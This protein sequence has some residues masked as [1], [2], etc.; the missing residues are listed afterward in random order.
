MAEYNSREGV[1]I[2][3]KDIAV[4]VETQKTV[5]DGLMQL[6]GQR[7]RVYIAGTNKKAVNEAIEKTKNTTIGVMDN[8]GNIVKKSTRKRS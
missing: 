1:D 2:N 8:K 6:Q 7:K 4:E 3:T 5:Q